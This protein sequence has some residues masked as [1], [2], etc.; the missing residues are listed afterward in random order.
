VKEEMRRERRMSHIETLGV[1]IQLASTLLKK[2]RIERESRD[3]RNSG[4]MD[5]SAE[6]A[7][8]N[9]KGKQIV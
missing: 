1:K 5:W 8:Q 2:L 4:D 7:L 6:V 3:R 9:E